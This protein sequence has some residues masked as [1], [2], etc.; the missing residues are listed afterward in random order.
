MKSL[1]RA[2]TTAG[3]LAVIGIAAWAQIGGAVEARAGTRA[4]RSEA[5]AAFFAD[6]VDYGS[7]ALSAASRDVRLS[8][9]YKQ[10]IDR[11]AGTGEMRACSAAE[12]RQLEALMQAAFRNA[13]L[14]RSGAAARDTLRADQRAW[15]RSRAEQCRRQVE[16]DGDAGGSMALLALD[17]CALHEV[18]RRTVWLERP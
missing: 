4:A 8:A 5:A 3:S 2:L 10:C 18:V 1:M 17:S 14:R 7:F 12:Y 9:E 11:A 6:H 15:D 16:Q 13:V